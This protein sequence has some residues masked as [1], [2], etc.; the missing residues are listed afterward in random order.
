[1]KNIKGIAVVSDGNLKRIA[2]T[3]DIIDEDGTIK[4]SNGRVNKIVVDADT[5]SAISSVE[6]Y[7]Q[8]VVDALEER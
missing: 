2:I 8:T 5:I 4:S 3:F 7:A 6:A 1:M